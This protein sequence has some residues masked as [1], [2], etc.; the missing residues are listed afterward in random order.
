[1][2]AIGALVAL[3]APGSAA[4]DPS[5]E[6]IWTA[7]T[8]DGVTGGGAINALP[9]DTLTLDIV[10]NDN[11]GGLSGAFLTLEYDS[12]NLLGMTAVN[13]PSPPNPLPE[14]CGADFL[15]PLVPSVTISN[16]GAGSTLSLFSPFDLDGT[17][18]TGFAMTVGRATFV[19]AGG[20][21]SVSLLYQPGLEWITDNSF[22]GFSP[23]ASALVG[24]AGLDT[25]EDGLSDGDEWILHGTDPLD[26]D[27]DDDGLEDGAEVTAGTDPLNE[28]TDGDD[29]CDGPIPVGICSQAGPDN[30]PFIMNFDQANSD[31][32]SAGDACQCGDLNLDNVVNGADALLARQHVVCAT[33]AGTCDLRRCNVVGP[34]GSGVGSDCN[35]GLHSDCGAGVPSDC[36]VADVYVLERLAAGQPAIIENTCQSY[37]GP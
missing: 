1:M 3:L 19:M 30:C 28:D 5:V 18:T 35:V 29:V 7:T 27:S 24:D 8:G 25:D 12:T 9:G 2:A 21:S 20:N 32:Y 23:P 22:A 36:D 10:V 4:A 16:V 33:I 17:S 6:L 34:A 26:P 13:C 31:P 37:T 15:Q 11:G 14:R